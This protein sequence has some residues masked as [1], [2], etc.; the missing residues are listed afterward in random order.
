MLDYT[1]ESP[2]ERNK[3]VQQFLEE[4]PDVNESYLEVLADYLVL[5][6]EKQER[7]ERKILTDNRLATIDKRETSLEGLIGQLENGE[8]GIYNLMKEDK[9][10]IFQPKVTITKQDLEDIPE[11][12]QLRESIAR[13]EQ[14]SKTASG[15]AAYIIKSTLIELRKD[16]YVIKNAYRNPIIFT[17]LTHGGRFTT[18][19]PFDEWIDPETKEVKN[20][21]ISFLNP[22]VISTILCNYTKLK[23]HCEKTVQSDTWCLMMDFDKL[24][25]E[26]LEP[27]PM[28]QRIVEYKI[29]N[30]DNKEIQLELQR[31]FKYTHS[32][33][34]ISSLW[35]NKIPRV[36]AGHALDEWLYWYY[37]NVE[38][39]MWK[40][41]S[42]CG[43]IK[44]AHS[45]FFSINNT[46]KDGFYSICKACR[47]KRSER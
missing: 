9:N 4:H 8:D 3:V 10:A 2:E 26:A 17:K 35:R 32:A 28:Y 16:Q 18:E 21:G 24:L 46:S 15:R 23:L 43:Q 41:C 12:R 13:W 34:Y 20:S 5:C 29:G 38:I 1:I 19:L 25:R 31:E 40:K 39:G 33:E 36:I 14:R 44:L 7:K 42:R 6:M 47:N 37:T 27:Y 30:Y 45:R 11:L 22:V